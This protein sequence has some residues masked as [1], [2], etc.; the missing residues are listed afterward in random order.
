MIFLVESV[1]VVG[2]WVGGILVMVLMLVGKLVW[3]S[4]GTDRA[5]ILQLSLAGE[6]AGRRGWN[7]RLDRAS[8]EPLRGLMNT[9]P[10]WL[11]LTTLL[12]KMIQKGHLKK[13]GPENCRWIYDSPL[14]R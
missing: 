2:T 9:G 11:N 4:L 12:F 7:M 1:L 6:G 13:K 3:V 10:G 14:F 5:H 8:G